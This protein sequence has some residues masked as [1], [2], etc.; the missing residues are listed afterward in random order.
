MTFHSACV[1]ILRRDIDRLGF[2]R[3][4]TIYDTSDSQS[5]MKRILKE[6]DMD[7]KT[8]PPRTLLGTISR[9]KDDMV[10]GGGVLCSR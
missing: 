8:Y 7:D 3:A 2:D 1:R 9:A 6:L 5:L 4:F 10:L